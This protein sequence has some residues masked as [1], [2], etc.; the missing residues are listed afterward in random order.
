MA[1][2]VAGLITDDD[3]LF[4]SKYPLATGLRGPVAF[5]SKMGS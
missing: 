2:E 5:S 3:Y 1:S 4:S